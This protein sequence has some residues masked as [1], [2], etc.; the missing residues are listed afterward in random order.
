MPKEFYFVSDLHFGGDGQLMVCDF[1]EE[2]IAFLQR[3]AQKDK[4]TEL[5]IAGDTFGFWELTTVQGAKQLDEIIKYH[6]EIFNQFKVTGEKIQITMVVGN[7]DYDLACDPEYAEKLADYNI[8]LDTSLA[9]IR[10]INDRKIFIEHG[11]QVDPYNAATEYG[12][13]HALPMGYFITESLVSGA[14]KYSVF[15]RSDWLKDIRSVDVRQIPDWLVSN[16][17]YNEMNII[18]RWLLLP[19]L[20]LLT[21][22][23]LAL[24]GQLL[25]YLR[26]FDVNYL[27][28]NPVIRALGL[29]G[30]VLSWIITAS[31]FVWSFVFV[32]SIPLYFVYRDIR[33]T[34]FRMQIFPSYKSA[35]TEEANHIYLERAR[36]VFAENPEVCAYLFGHTHDAFLVKEKGRVIINTGTWLKILRRVSVRFGLLPGIYYPT[37]RLNYFKIY[38][39]AKKIV[40]KYMEIPKKNVEKLT[41]LQRFLIFGRKPDKAKPIPKRTIL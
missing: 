35:P 8:R 9:L 41:L 3:L 30:D 28:D 37:F 24:G 16:Y 11:Q 21:V 33:R 4:E 22:T 12:N 29:F 2:F 19:F 6:T 23:A 15:G 32:V 39:E 18:L 5:I 34:L 25:K 20:L 10:E 7:H 26:I 38:S 13:I 40:V 36:S 1:T 17:F 14:S 27:L 31:M